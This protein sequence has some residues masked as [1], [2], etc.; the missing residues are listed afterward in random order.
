MRT[1]RRHHMQIQVSAVRIPRQQNPQ[2]GRRSTTA[3]IQKLHALAL[4]P[5]R[6]AH[7]N[8]VTPSG[9]RKRPVE[10][11]RLINLQRHAHTIDDQV[12]RHSGGLRG[13]LDHTHD[14]RRI[15]LARRGVDRRGRVVDGLAEVFAVRGAGVPAALGGVELDAAVSMDRVQHNQGAEEQDYGGDAQFHGLFQ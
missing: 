5:I 12:P 9:K 13:A 11:P 15:R 1:I 14:P 3:H 10:I 4:L 8:A 2:L 6:A 7:F